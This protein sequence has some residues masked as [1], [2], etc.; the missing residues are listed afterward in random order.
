MLQWVHT[1]MHADTMRGARTRAHVLQAAGHDG[2]G[3]A[4]QGGVASKGTGGAPGQQ[5]APQAA[6]VPKGEALQRGAAM[7]KQA[8]KDGI[9]Y[10]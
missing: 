6:Q 7:H 10:V 3:G 2:P 5:H 1:C 9:R 4:Q 8:R